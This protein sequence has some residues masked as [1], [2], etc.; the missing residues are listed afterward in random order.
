MEKKKA[1]DMYWIFI[2][3]AIGLF[4][5]GVIK[6]FSPANPYEGLLL[7]GFGVLSLALSIL[8]KRKPKKNEK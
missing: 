7:I 2:A 4:G 1:F 8:I 3:G 6:L 5:L